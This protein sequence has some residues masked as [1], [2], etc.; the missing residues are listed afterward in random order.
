MGIINH[1]TI[2][3]ENGIEINDTYYSLHN[4]GINL[5]KN[6]SGTFC[7][8]VDF[9]I[10]KDKDF[11]IDSQ[12]TTATIEEFTPI[13]YHTIII[14]SLTIEQATNDLLNYSY[15]RLKLELNNYT[16]DV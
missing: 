8:Q 5:R 3:L 15:D 16:D 9:T 2:T 14:D 1:D 13:K 11:R 4:S 12:N 7:F 6:E 10:W